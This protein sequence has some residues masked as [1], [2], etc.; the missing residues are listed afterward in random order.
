MEVWCIMVKIFK[1]VNKMKKRLSAVLKKLNDE[2]KK[3]LQDCV[4]DYEDKQNK[5]EE[6]KERLTFALEGSNSGLWDWDIETDE[7]YFDS[8][9]YK[10]S[11][12]DVDD[13]PH[14]FEEWKIRVHPEDLQFALKKLNDCLKG[15]IDRYSLEFRFKKKSGDWMWILG[16]GKIFEYDEEGKPLRFA[17]THVDITSLK[18][19]EIELLEA[20]E[21]FENIF[22]NNPVPMWLEDFSK[23]IKKFKKLKKNGIVD[24][25]D[26]LKNNSEFIDECINSIKIIDVNKAALNLHNAKSKSQLLERFD[27]TFTEASYD[28][29]ENELIGLWNGKDR[30]SLET[31]VK[32]LDGELRFVNVI[33]NVLKDVRKD[34]SRVLI[35]MYDMTERREFLAS[36][37]KERNTAQLYLDIS[38]HLFLALN[39]K[40]EITLINKKGCEILGYDNEEQLLG[41]K[42]AENFI[43]KKY[44]EDIN[45][46]FSKLLDGEFKIFEYYENP[47]ISK[48]GEI[49]EIAWH[50]ALIKNENG[51]IIGTLSSGDDVTDKKKS[52]KA[53]IESQRLGAIGEMATAVA[54]D[55]NNNLQTIFGNLE[56]VLMNE[57]LPKSIRKHIET[58]KSSAEDAASKVL[59]LQRFG[60]TKKGTNTYNSLDLNILI[61]DVIE[62]AKPMWKDKAHKKGIDIKICL[63]LSEIPLILGNIGELRTVLFTIVKNC[64]EAMPEGG[65]I[66]I[67]TFKKDKSVYV[68]VSDTGVGMTKEVSS[69][70]FQP[71]YSTKGYELS[72]GFGMSGAYSII[73][74]H[75]GKI[76]VLKTEEGKGTT[77]EFSIPYANGKKNKKQCEECKSSKKRILWVDDEENIREI[78]EQYLELLDFKG[79]VV[80]SGEEALLCLSKNKYD[81]VI[82]DIG[83]LGINGWQL[84]RKIKEQFNGN[85]KVIVLT[86][87]GAE[88]SEEKKKEHNV[89]HVLGKPVSLKELERCIVNTLNK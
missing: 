33:L 78:A 35:S 56:L 34:Y 89:L 13:F 44:Q 41:K 21:Y 37:I 10:I 52:E 18:E 46:Q 55:F 26:Y 81:L 50:N 84:S 27:N 59:M 88:I 86:G 36:I 4:N 43:P 17:G 40:G 85:M 68:R 6:Y 82:T 1:K 32:T 20:K 51:E 16:Q 54:H 87:W 15:K 66:A 29:F 58:V 7:V 11:G 39:R 31:E 75:G 63:N 60:G 53:L 49:K 77:I 3:V 70:V 80:E 71:F 74:E 19:K 61:K 48:S 42:W 2:N 69:R 14:S 23:T 28:A 30:I 12:Y 5:L 64:Y 83:M 62:Q 8:N 57:D 24:L 76:S 73:S 9:Y 72:R 38:G 25:K 65:Q 67:E 79:D 47:I 45:S 22:M